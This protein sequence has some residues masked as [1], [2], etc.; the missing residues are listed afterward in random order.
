[1]VAV[2]PVQI[3]YYSRRGNE[4]IPYQTFFFLQ[5]GKKYEEQEKTKYTSEMHDM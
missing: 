2:C 5:T 3:N 1:M 4:E